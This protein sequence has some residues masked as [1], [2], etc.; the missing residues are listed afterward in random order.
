LLIGDEPP[1]YFPIFSM[2][3]ENE[4]GVSLCVIERPES[5]RMFKMAVQQGRSE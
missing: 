2:F 1:G 4:S 5:C 3:Q